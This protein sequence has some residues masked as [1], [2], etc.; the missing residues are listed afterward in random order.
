MELGFTAPIEGM[1]LKP[2][3][4]SVTMRDIKVAHSTIGTVNIEL[5]QALVNEG[6]YDAKG[7]IN[8]FLQN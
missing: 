8:T 1:A 3:V 6:L 2:N 7:P 5:L 4:S